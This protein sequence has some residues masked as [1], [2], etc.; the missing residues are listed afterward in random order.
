ME[1]TLRAPGPLDV[2]RTLE[3]FRRWGEDPANRLA[4]RV[5]RRAVKCDGRWRGYELQWAGGVDAARLTVTVPGARSARVVDRALGEVRGILGLDLDLAGFYRAAAA[6]PIVGPLT[7]RLYGLRPTLAPEPFE[8]LVGAVCAQQVNLAW[9]FTVRG[10]IVRR[11]GTRV[12]TPGEPVFGFPEPEALARVM[13]AELRALGLTQRKAE[14]IVGLAAAV[15][16]ERL[17][18]AL[19]AR[20]PNEDVV[21]ALTEVRG[22]GRWTAEWFLARCLGRGNVCPAGDL[23]VRKAFG[24]FYHRGR[25]PSEE[26]V[27]RR[28]ARWGGDQNLMVHYLLAGQRLDQAPGGEAT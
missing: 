16:S 13:P 1:L 6:D 27:R 3:R 11:F 28:A 12:A 15:A 9:A 17:D 22:L 20:R 4:D 19:L 10:R 8:M 21:G 23:G 25:M 24:H 26:A 5:F 7:E 14:Y 2:P 18:L